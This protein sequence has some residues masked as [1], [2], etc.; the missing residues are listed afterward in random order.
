MS[1]HHA[2]GSAGHA[3]ARR[4]AFAVMVIASA[5]ALLSGGLACSHHKSAPQSAGSS[6][7]ASSS[8][9]GPVVP[10]G[11]EQ[12]VRVIGISPSAGPSGE[13]IVLTGKGLSEVS[14][15]CFGDIPGTQ[16]AVSS[17]ARLTVLSPVGSGIVDVTVITPKGSFTAGSFTYRNPAGLGSPSARP[18]PSSRCAQSPSP[19]QAT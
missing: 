17:A 8:G 2:P 5:I 9:V 16:L 12:T 18:V 15:V 14:T 19:D 11:P 7:T 1:A 10:T 3:P 13:R 4:P 6:P